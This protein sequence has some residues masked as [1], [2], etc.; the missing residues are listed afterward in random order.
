MAAR[1]NGP[2]TPPRRVPIQERSKRRV[3]T[4]LEA[5][6]L[7]F[8][9]VGYEAATMEGI[10]ARAETSIGSVYQFYPNKQALFAAVAATTLQRS[11]AAFE[12]L[13]EGPWEVDWKDALGL[14]VDGLTALR[15]TDPAFRAILV[16]FHLYGMYAEADLALHRYFVE[17]VADN[18]AVEAPGLPPARRQVLATMVVHVVSAMLFL[19]NR[20]EPAMGRKMIEETKR[21]LVAYLEPHVLEGRRAKARV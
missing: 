15:E 17:R 21:M 11:R 12:Q 14:M 8:A 18:M 2:K 9:E 20:E 16:N 1:N 3:E 5:A 19:S 13:L 10:A 6:A 4:I 7:V